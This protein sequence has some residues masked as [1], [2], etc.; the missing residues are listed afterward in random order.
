MTTETFIELAK[1]IHG[2]KYDYSKTKYVHNS[3]KVK[4]IC[5]EHGSFEQAAIDHTSRKH[6][7]RKCGQKF[8]NNNKRLN[9][10]DFIKMAKEIHGDLY[11]YSKTTYNK[12]H[13]KIKIICHIHGEFEQIASNHLKGKGCKKCATESF[14]KTHNTGT[15]K[16][17]EKAEKIHGKR[18]DYT[19]VKYIN[20]YS[21]VEVLCKKHGSFFLSGTNHLRGKGCPKCINKSEG[22]VGKLLEK[23][24]PEWT[25]FYNKTIYIGKRRRRFDYR[26]EN[27]GNKV[28]VEYDGQQH[29]RP[30]DFG[31]HS[32]E[33]TL[34][35]HVN[36]KRKDRLDYAYCKYH[37]II[38]H[39][40]KY[41]KDKEKSILELKERLST[42]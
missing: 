21:K 42:M 24:F 39:R 25:I 15:K 2:D 27:N 7:C 28:I 17:I 3:M 33:K 26:L 6:G 5:P 22:D 40:I 23:Y 41:N 9:I 37:N 8:V 30:I 20:A 31:G 36:Q 1:S 10:E 4:I 16:F 32:K 38:L 34:E 11:D 35:N 12:Y 18:Y 14:A 29:F 13:G 19:K